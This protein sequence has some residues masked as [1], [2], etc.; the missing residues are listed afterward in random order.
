MAYHPWYIF[1]ALYIPWVRNENGR[2]KIWSQNLGHTLSPMNK[3]ILVFICQIEMCPQYTDAPAVGYLTIKLQ[4][5]TWYKC[6]NLSLTG[7]HMYVHTFVQKD[8]HS[9]THTHIRTYGKPKK[10]MP[11]GIIFIQSKFFMS[12]MRGHKKLWLGK[13]KWENQWTHWIPETFSSLL[14]CFLI[15]LLS[16]DLLQPLEIEHKVTFSNCFQLPRRKEK[17]TEPGNPDNN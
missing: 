15:T 11:P 1:S 2:R 9:Y 17:M 16:L 13:E 14:C 10:Y 3:Y 8:V 4:N 6:L 7:S 5:S 12:P